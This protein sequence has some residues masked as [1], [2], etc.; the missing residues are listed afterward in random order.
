L[1]CSDM[2][3]RTLYDK[4]HVHEWIYTAGKFSSTN[5]YQV[6]GSNYRYTSTGR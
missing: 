6:D 2:I 5:D 3:T 4:R 1:K